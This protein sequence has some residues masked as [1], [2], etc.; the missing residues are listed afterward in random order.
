MG[1]PTGGN[2]FLGEEE[3]TSGVMLEFHQMGEYTDLVAVDSAVEGLR[4]QIEEVGYEI[5][6]AEVGVH[7]G[8]DNTGKNASFFEIIILAERE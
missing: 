1:K 4:A 6:S 7:V 8:K 3:E 2:P 5:M